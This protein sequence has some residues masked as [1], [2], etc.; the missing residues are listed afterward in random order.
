[1]TKRKIL[2]PFRGVRIYITPNLDMPPNWDESR[3]HQS[4]RFRPSVS[5]D[6]LSE[7]YPVVAAVG[8]GYMRIVFIRY[9]AMT[10]L[11]MSSFG[12]FR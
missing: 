2:F 9:P 12:P 1:M 8:A 3:F 11:W 7:E 5:V 4:H 6:R 10:F